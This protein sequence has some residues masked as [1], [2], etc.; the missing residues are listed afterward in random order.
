MAEKRSALTTLN[1]KSLRI[2]L[3]LFFIALMVPTV[4]LVNRAYEELQWESFYQ[5]RVQAE[6]L[7]NRIDQRLIEL[8]NH[9]EQRGYADY[10]F[11][12]VT[13]SKQANFLQR[14][15]LARFPVESDIPGLLGYFQVASDGQFTTPLLPQDP[16]ANR[17]GISDDEYQQRLG[18]QMKLLDIL[19]KNRLVKSKLQRLDTKASV[20]SPGITPSAPIAE[21]DYSITD[22]IAASS[23]PVIAKELLAPSAEIPAAESEESARLEAPILASPKISQQAFDELESTSAEPEARVMK[24]SKLGRIADLKLD[25][26][27]QSRADR[28]RNEEQAKE[29]EESSFSKLLS[30]S[31]GEKKLRREISQ[32]PETRPAIQTAN[33]NTMIADQDVRIRI[34]ESEIDAFELSML[35]SGHFVLFRK[36]WRNGQR[37]IQGLLIEQQPF[38]KGLISNAYHDTA[39]SSISHLLVAWQGNVVS[40]IDAIGKREY[41]ARS[42]KLSGTLL[43]QAPLSQPLDEMEL[44]F[45]INQL[46]VGPGARVI[47][48]IAGLLILVLIIGLYLVYRT[49][50]RQLLLVQQQQDFVSAVSHELKTPL[51]SIRMHGEMLQEEWA[52]EEKKK[53]YYNLIVNESERLTRLINN[54]LQLARFS[55]NAIQT[56]TREVSINELIDLTKSAIKTPINASDF[57]LDIQC[58][59]DIGTNIIRVD[60]DHFVQIMINLVDNAIKFSTKAEYK[61]IEVRCMKTFDDLLQ[62]SIRDYGPG[63]PRDQMKKIFTLFYRAENE[64]TRETIGTG[65]GLSLVNQLIREMDAS[66]DV[67]NANPGARFVLSFQSID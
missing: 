11:L 48:W 39:L 51:T 52:S 3:L 58:N 28:T 16:D 59:D 4:L 24:K 10:A 21:D 7:T 57:T 2:G 37:I 60:T 18:L 44:V 14:S 29:L 38:I 65:I 15:P 45:T 8:I 25:K 63:I 6:E 30:S 40:R 5:Q 61:T 47:N 66:I 64:L 34:F 54:V 42:D 55:R 43:Y 27:Y 26:D 32:L 67:E 33:P 9:E 35:D 20:S 1:L 46:P 31:Q 36:V 56:N 12:N 50:V 62:I 19:D 22:G 13:G 41:L 49:G 17:Y 23:K 53:H